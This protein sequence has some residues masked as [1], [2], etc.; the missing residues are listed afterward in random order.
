M[1]FSGR[2]VAPVPPPAQK[3]VP[4]HP[5]GPGN[6]PD[7]DRIPVLCGNPSG[8]R[9]TRGIPGNG[10]ACK[11]MLMRSRSHFPCPFMET[12]AH[13]PRTKRTTAWLALMLFLLGQ[14][15]PCPARAEVGTT[16]SQVQCEYLGLDWQ[17]AYLELLTDGFGIIRLGAYWD[18]IEH[19]ENVYDFAELDWQI[20]HARRNN[21]PVVLCVG[22]KAPRW[23]EFFIPAWVADSIYLKFGA[24]VASNEYLAERTL[25]F[26]TAV[27]CH[28]RNN[29]AIRYWQIENEP[30]N[31]S[32]PKNW[33]I[34]KSFLEKEIALAKVLDPRHRPVIV[35]IATYPNPAIRFFAQL[36]IS[37]D[38][39]AEAIEACD[40]LA[41]NVYPVVGQ[42]LWGI[43]FCFWTKPRQRRA[44]LS[45]IAEASRRKNKPVW[46]T[47]LQAEPWEPGQLVHV[48]GDMPITCMPES[49]AQSYDELTTLGIDT[50][51]LWGT[52]YWYF[53]E[54]RHGDEN[55]R[56]QGMAILRKS[57]LQPT[58]HRPSPGAAAAVS[59]FRSSHALPAADGIF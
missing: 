25:K 28:Y 43:K 5:P 10:P 6:V 11:N 7:A 40:I 33:W 46:A 47:E 41:V 37:N 54:L 19:R 15:G 34:N 56:K 18:R 44:Y 8:K 45:R 32:G 53:R 9:R 38:P 51:L 49:F 55:W 36:N 17:K 23:P 52:E 50:V 14:A 24:D 35:N 1:I 31:R 59:P 20:E 48:T 29:P 3:R 2:M 22:M 42:R 57:R 12:T 4:G 13:P 21:L 39:V 27:V 30:L 58:A 26:I 16:F